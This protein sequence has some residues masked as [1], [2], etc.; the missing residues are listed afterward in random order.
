MARL[1]GGGESP[2]MGCRYARDFLGRRTTN[3]NNV[4]T[5]TA[6][7]TSVEALEA[8]ED[9]EFEEDVRR[10]QQDDTAK[11]IDESH[12]WLKTH[13][14]WPARFATRPLA[15]TKTPPSPPSKSWKAGLVAGDIQRQG[16]TM[17][18]SIRRQASYYYG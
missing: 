8:E 5:K 6:L 15:A 17:G 11:G 16:D 7:R 12:P 9:M 3:S 4:G 1:C 10:N 18:R 13:T 2:T 14:R